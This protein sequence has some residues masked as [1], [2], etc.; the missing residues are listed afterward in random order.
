MHMLTAQA[1]AGGEQ[2]P[3]LYSNGEPYVVREADQTFRIVEY[4]GKR[5]AHALGGLLGSLVGGARGVGEADQPFRY[6]AS[7]GVRCAR[8][9][10]KQSA[11]SARM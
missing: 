9:A 2:G 4:T 11:G 8:A 3:M 1:V 5:C 10:C 7:T 6:Q